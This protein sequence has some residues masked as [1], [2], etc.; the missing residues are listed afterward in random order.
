[1]FGG[2]G[3]IGRRICEVL[4]QVG[5]CDVCS[6]SR[7][8]KPPSYYCDPS[9]SDKVQWISYDLEQEDGDDSSD[10]AK[11]QLLEHI[12]AIDSAISC[13]GG[14]HPTP[15]WKQLFGLGFDDDRLLKENG[16][17]N[18]QVC[19]ISKE[20][21]AES[22]VL[23]SPS[24]ETSKA[25]EGPIPGYCDGKRQ[26]ESKAA[27]VFG[28][29]QTI[30]LGPHLVYGGKRFPTV[31]RVYRAFVES[32][33]AK[34]YVG[35][36]DFLRNLSVAPLDDW[37]EKMI[38]SSPVLVESVARVASAGALGQISKSMVGP[39]TQGFFDTKGQ[40]VFYDD[41]VFI[42]GTSEIERIEQALAENWKKVVLTS[43]PQSGKGKEPFWEG[44][45]IGKQPYLFPLPVVATFAIIFW[46]I[47]TQQFVQVVS[48][49]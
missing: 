6:I 23:M 13:I 16:Q 43:S 48:D 33:P 28:A 49:I 21:G 29:N 38:F 45:L 47:S 12:G 9:W 10:T 7:S 14:I 8:G 5:G 35:V 39:R 2:S 31:G 36:N 17:W 18:E 3:F 19:D 20:A 32:F 22:F 42:D 41:V 46:A 44:A 26:A 30:I 37:V 24:Y 25:L 34:A 11:K 4:V 27:A 40:P 1:V 15:E